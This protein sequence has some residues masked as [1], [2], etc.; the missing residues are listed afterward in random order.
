[1][2]IFENDINYNSE[3]LI[4]KLERIKNGNYIRYSTA[5]LPYDENEQ[6]FRLSKILE[7]YTKD[8]SGIYVP[9]KWVT[10]SINKY[11]TLSYEEQIKS[12]NYLLSSPN[13]IEEFPGGHGL[14]IKHNIFRVP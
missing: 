8:E 6:E 9:T 5:I 14:S 12:I 4:E 13:D 1:M 3:E 11:L 7:S 10:V 2:S